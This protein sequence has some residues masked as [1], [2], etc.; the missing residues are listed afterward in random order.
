MICWKIP[1]G[2]LRKKLIFQYTAEVPFLSKSHFDK[3]WDF[4]KFPSKIKIPGFHRILALFSVFFPEILR[5]GKWSF[6]EMLSKSHICYTDSKTHL[7]HA[8]VSMM[9]CASMC[10]NWMENNSHATSTPEEEIREFD[11]IKFLLLEKTLI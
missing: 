8:F 11:S 6:R 7:W 5:S 3:E 4:W 2:I 9:I 10:I 1:W